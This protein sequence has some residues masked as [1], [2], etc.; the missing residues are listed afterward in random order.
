MTQCSWSHMVMINIR[1]DHI[2]SQSMRSF[3]TY[4]QY[5]SHKHIW[6]WPASAVHIVTWFALLLQKMN[7]GLEQWISAH[8]KFCETKPNQG[9]NATELL[10]H[11]FRPEEINYGWE[12]TIGNSLSE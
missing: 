12:N 5:L 11:R 9:E 2:P 6:L 8:L 4:L 7:G 10:V 1:G 3:F